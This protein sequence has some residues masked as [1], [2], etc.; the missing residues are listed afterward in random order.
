MSEEEKRRKEE[1]KAKKVLQKEVEIKYNLLKNNMLYSQ[2]SIVRKLHLLD[3]K[4]SPASFSKMVRGTKV[5]FRLLSVT[6]RG[7]DSLIE[8]ELGVKYNKESGKFISIS[9]PDWEP[10]IIEDHQ[11]TDQ[12]LVFHKEGRL[13][14]SKEVEIIKTAVIEV[15][16]LGRSLTELVWAFRGRRDG[17]FKVHIE[18]ALSRGV[19]I[20]CYVVDTENNRFRLFLQDVMEVSTKEEGVGDSKRSIEALVEIA[21][22]LNSAKNEG[23]MLVYQYSHIPTASYMIVDGAKSNGK[24]LAS[25]YLFGESMANSPV[26]EI[27]KKDGDYLYHTYHQSFLRMIDGAKKINGAKGL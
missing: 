12:S 6:N 11:E 14:I 10:D 20:K 9:D 4:V 18:R 1:E 25:H 26:L 7:L 5:G 23:R 16:F 22:E 13:S 21:E 8:R 27:N 24:I 15:T 3:A 2:I 17:E 19:N